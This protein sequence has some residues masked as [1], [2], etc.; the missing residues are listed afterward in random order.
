MDVNLSDLDAA[1]GDK[2]A[3]QKITAG[4]SQNIWLC[5]FKCF[6][7]ESTSRTACIVLINEP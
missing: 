4:V 7:P 1:P 3:G 6:P 2:L 5:P